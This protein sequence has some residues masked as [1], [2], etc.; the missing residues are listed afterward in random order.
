MQ[1]ISNLA[2]AAKRYKII[3]LRFTYASC[4][5]R[6]TFLLKKSFVAKFN[7][8]SSQFHIYMTEGILLTLWFMICYWISICV[9][10][11]FQREPVIIGIC[12]YVVICRSTSV[13][14]FASYQCHNTIS[15]ITWSCFSVSNITAYSLC[16]KYLE[17]MTKI[18]LKV[19]N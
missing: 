10:L 13:L 8:F 17:I 15:L 7:S 1:T 2:S 3:Q 12:N 5:L 16:C 11:M 9:K 19:V 6:I 18:W 4:G 14:H